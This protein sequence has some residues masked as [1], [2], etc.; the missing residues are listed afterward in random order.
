MWQ[1]SGVTSGTPASVVVVG[2][3]LAGLTCAAGLASAGCATT[4]VTAGRAGRDGATHRVHGLAPWI[5]LTAPWARGDSPAR[6]LADL[7]RR[8]AGCERDG[9]AEVLAESSHAAA[10]G[11]IEELDLEPMDGGPVTL[12][13]DELP[14]GR[15]CI[16]RRP[17]LLLAPLLARCAAAGV[18]VLERTVVF[19]LVLE[20]DG[21]AGVLALARDGAAPVTLGAD[22]VVLASGGCGAVFPITTSPRW[23]RG[24]GIALAAAAGALL[25]R[26]GLVQALPVTA[27]PPLFF[28]SSAALL[29]SRIEIG[30]SALP[31]DR[32]VDGTTL[33][34]ARAV[35]AGTPVVLEPSET[36]AAILPS[37]VR[38]SAAFRRD[39]RVPLTVA[40][41]HSIG[42]VAIDAWGRTSLPGLYACGEAAGGVQGRR[43]TMGTGLVE[44]AVFGAR[45]ARAAAADAPR[46][47]RRHLGGGVWAAPAIPSEPARLER[48]LDRLMGPLVMVRPSETVEDA[49]R[50]L[51]AWP[52]ASAGTAALASADV[53]AA[54][55]LGAAL[56]MLQG[57]RED[58]PGG[59]AVAPGPER[60]EVRWRT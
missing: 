8:G 28:P 29:G 38:S 50:E 48:R 57:F 37:R 13:G 4:L 10:V 42:G 20:D 34:I 55:R 49:A 40:G 25:H 6:Y 52:H 11:L 35:R 46:R 27:T 15:R 59:A 43:R 31:N 45:A 21:V 33:A 14:R 17:H 39:G 24:T 58:H 60:G 18:R 16:P 2:S 54:I 7:K 32:D 22:A 41:H 23:C 30:G 12:P 44:A 1:T 9:L 5:L 47:G 26:P 56:A 19:G 51:A 36:A 53:L 3:G